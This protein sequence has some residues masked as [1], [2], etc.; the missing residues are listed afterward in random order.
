MV[1]DRVWV[2]GWWI[3]AITVTP[4]PEQSHNAAPWPCISQTL[5]CGNCLN[6]WPATSEPGPK[7][8]NTQKC[9]KD[10]LPARD[11]RTASDI[12]GGLHDKRKFQSFQTFQTFQTTR[13]SGYTIIVIGI[14]S[15]HIPT[16]GGIAMVISCYLFYPLTTPTAPPSGLLGSSL[17]HRATMFDAAAESRPLVGSSQSSTSNWDGLIASC[18]DTGYIISTGWSNSAPVA[19]H[20]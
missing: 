14:L 15:Q 18:G 19:D 7:C 11:L 6:S 10:V 2:S 1:R 13:T 8:R 9:N 5:T 12:A 16:Y 3:A 20:Q 17:R 4:R